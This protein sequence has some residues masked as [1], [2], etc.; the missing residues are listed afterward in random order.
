MI[1][2]PTSELCT[3]IILIW[4]FSILGLDLS[5]KISLPSF[6]RHTF[7]ITTTDYF[8]KWVEPISL[9]STTTNAICCFILEH[10]ISPFDFPF[11]LVSD[12]GTPFKNNDVNKFLEIFNIQHHFSTP[13]Y[14]QSNGQVEA[15]NK[16]IEQ[17]MWKIV[18]KHNKDL[19]TQLTYSLW[20]YYTSVTTS[21]GNTSYS[22]VYGVEAIIPL[23]F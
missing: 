21:T 18:R 23:E 20:A 2:A 7:N 1:Q 12:N 5:G 4:P 15:T 19:H 3:H 17:I 10:I 9:H 16:T 14:L 8:T 6:V 22:L 11:A 13:Y